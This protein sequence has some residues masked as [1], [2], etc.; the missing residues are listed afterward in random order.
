MIFTRRDTIFSV[1]VA[2][3]VVMLILQQITIS[4]LSA[5]STQQEA[6]QEQKNVQDNDAIKNILREAGPATTSNPGSTL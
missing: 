5:Q 3:L 6:R 1:V 2:T 4:R